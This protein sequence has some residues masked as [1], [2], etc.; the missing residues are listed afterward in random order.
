M[1]LVFVCLKEDNFLLYFAL[2]VT[3]CFPRITALNVALCFETITVKHTAAKD[4]EILYTAL[5]LPVSW[6]LY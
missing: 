1:H 3:F 5:N 2:D 4:S 6:V